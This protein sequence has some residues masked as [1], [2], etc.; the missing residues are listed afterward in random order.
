LALLRAARSRAALAGR[1]FTTP[2]DVK[3]M[4]VPVLAHRLV[5]RTEAWVRGTREVDVVNDCLASIPT[6]ATLTD[7]D[8]EAAVQSTVG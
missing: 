3:S 4:A 7:D 5:L 6:P 1:D 2:N 8:V